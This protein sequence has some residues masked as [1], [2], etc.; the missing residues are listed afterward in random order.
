MGHTEGMR[1]LAGVWLLLLSL[2]GIA[3]TTVSLDS[4]PDRRIEPGDRFRVE[5]S[6]PTLA[7]EYSV[8]SHG[9]L[10][11]GV[12][13]PVT[14]AGMT[15]TQAQE[16]LA[17][18]VRAALPAD[19]SPVKVSLLWRGDLPIRFTGAVTQPGMME[20]RED[21]TLEEALR[22]IQPQEGSEAT[23]VLVD[24]L[25]EKKL[26]ETDKPDV[27]GMRLAPGDHL[28]FVLSNRVREVF[29]LGAVAAP[30]SY[31]Y[32]GGLTLERAIALAGGLTPTANRNG[33]EVLRSNQAVHQP[34]DWNTEA[35]AFVLRPGDVV[36]IALKKERFFVGVDGFVRHPAI[37]DFDEGMTLLKAVNAVGGPADQADLS[38]VQILRVDG[39]R[40]VRTIHDLLSISRGLKAD[41]PLKPG[42]AIYVP[43]GKGAKSVPANVDLLIR[44]LTR[45]GG[46]G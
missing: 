18:S 44:R 10:D 40:Q 35:G 5:C 45:L 39:G 42:D 8:E 20:H 19:G 43:T 41:V 2:A 29:V 17:E 30:G 32:T 16:R 23:F 6:D 1:F 4:A 13:P 22:A 34:G 25:G 3:Q 46:R 9:R 26:V 21:L 7:R 28:H 38:K 12:I 11:L 33:I 15:V 31:P 37:L 24:Q 14:L 36:R 27:F